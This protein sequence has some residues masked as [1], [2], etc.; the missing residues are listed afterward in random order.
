MRSIAAKFTRKPLRFAGSDVTEEEMERYILVNRA[1]K[2]LKEAQDDIA[3][4]RVAP[5]EPLP[6]FLR[7]AREYSKQKRAFRAKR[8]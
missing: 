8:R 6:V 2:L 3:A 1:H 7:K 5:L 4:G